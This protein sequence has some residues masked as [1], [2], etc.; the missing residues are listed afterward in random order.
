MATDPVCKM[1]VDESSAAGRSE[2]R[3]V[4]YLF[5]AMD[6]KRAFDEDP[7]RYLA[8][9]REKPSFRHRWLRRSNSGRNRTA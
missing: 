7:E 2:F 3:G 1:T 4:T 6:C 8:A 9:P 5:C